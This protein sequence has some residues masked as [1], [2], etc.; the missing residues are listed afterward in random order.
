MRNET[1]YAL[2]KAY[3]QLNQIVTELYDAA[4]NAV[5]DSDASLLISR[6][7]ILYEQMENLDT[8]IT[9]LGE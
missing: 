2:L 1:R 9:E 4:D 6:A 7:D 5:D 8:V 3:N